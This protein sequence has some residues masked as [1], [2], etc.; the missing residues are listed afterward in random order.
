M[1]WHSSNHDYTWG[2]KL[3]FKAVKNSCVVREAARWGKGDGCCGARLRRPIAASLLFGSGRNK[4]PLLFFEFCVNTA[5]PSLLSLRLQSVL[6]YRTGWPRRE[7]PCFPFERKTT[8]RRW[9]WRTIRL[10][11]PP[12]D[13]VC[14]P[15][16][17][18]ARL[19]PTTASHP[20]TRT[21]RNLDPNGRPNPR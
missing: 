3:A 14:T 5:K 20:L 6:T 7:L 4:T 18:H 19:G 9:R 1:S 12:R 2:Y 16:G 17:W 13:T 8:K 15:S 10:G 21:N 11:E